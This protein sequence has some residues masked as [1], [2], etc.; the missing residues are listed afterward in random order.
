MKRFSHTDKCNG[1][2]RSSFTQWENTYCKRQ[3]LFST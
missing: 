3:H 2:E 1:D